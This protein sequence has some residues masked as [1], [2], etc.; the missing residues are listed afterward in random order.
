MAR[1]G[2]P[3]E[4]RALHLELR[5]MGDVGLVGAPNA[6][7]SS[8]LAALS[9]AKPEIGAYPFTTLT[10]NLGVATVEDLSFV[11]V[12][13]PGLIEGAHA[14]VGLGHQFLRHV[15]RA[16]ILVHVV[17]GAVEDPLESYQAVREEIRLFD[18]SLLDRAELVAVNKMDLPEARSRWT[19]L[20][21]ELLREGAGVFS[22]SALS[23]EGLLELEAAMKLCLEEARARASG[24]PALPLGVG[25][26]HASAVR[27]E[28]IRT[29]R[30]RRESEGY[31]V[32]RQHDGF[33]VRSRNVERIV[34]MADMDTDEGL[35][36][37]QRQLER[38]GLFRDLEREGVKPGD[39]VRI[40]DF[41]LEWA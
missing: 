16:G 34:A 10:P 32:E 7:K 13:I 23:G 24:S 5:T 26:R 27:G 37:L 11:V 33:T 8:L 6:G 30:V 17:D 14:G 40:G 20:R 21:R 3:G 35:A 38:L 9:A 39:T 4:E 12:D 28:G 31:T 41:E 36:D 25:A 18:P 19:E 15:Q 22:V 1:K 2:E 29:Y